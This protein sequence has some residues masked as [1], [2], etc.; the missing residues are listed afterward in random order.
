MVDEPELWDALDDYP[1]SENSMRFKLTIW[2]F[3]KS[4]NGLPS[5]E[6][7]GTDWIDQLKTN[8]SVVLKDLGI[9]KLPKLGQKIRR[10]GLDQAQLA[11][12]LFKPQTLFPPIRQETI[13]EVKGESIDGVLLLG[14]TKFFNSVVTAIDAGENTEERR[15]AYVAM[16]R[17]RHA[18]LAELPA[19]HFDRHAEKW[20]NWGF[21]AI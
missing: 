1:D 14:S 8:L 3:T 16:T 10:T 20:I 6:M 9:K 4:S 7:N 21:T 11:L 2:K 12:P 17:A 13:H 19:S 18:L 15:L 5:V